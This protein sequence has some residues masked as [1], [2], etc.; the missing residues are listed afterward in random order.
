MT[1][2]KDL[3]LTLKIAAI[4]GIRAFVYTVCLAILTAMLMLFGGI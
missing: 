2:F 1:T 4:G 3:N